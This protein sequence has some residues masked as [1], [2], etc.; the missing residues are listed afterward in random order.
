MHRS[1]SSQCTAVR[2]PILQMKKLRLRVIEGL[3]QVYTA[4]ERWNRVFDV[5]SGV[6]T[7]QCGVLVPCRVVV[8]S[9][10]LEPRP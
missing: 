8:V 3:E 4:V 6:P 5:K 9:T 7:A 1:L 2:V 10:D